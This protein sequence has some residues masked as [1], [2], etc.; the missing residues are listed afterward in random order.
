MP[1][2]QILIFRGTGGVLN[3]AHP[4]YSEAVLVRAGHVGMLGVIEDKIIGFH[5]TPEATENWEE[6][7]L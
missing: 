3:K 6:R 5:P 1:I 4:H 2:I 7:R